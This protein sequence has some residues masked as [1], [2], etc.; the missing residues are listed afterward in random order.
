MIMKRIFILLALVISIA[1]CTSLPKKLNKAKHLIE[2]NGGF[3]LPNKDSLPGQCAVQ[4]PCVT[5][6]KQVTDSGWLVI[7]TDNQA[8]VDS[9]KK[10]I[11]SMKAVLANPPVVTDSASCLQAVQYYQRKVAQYAIDISQLTSQIK[12]SST[13]YRQRTEKFT[14][15]STA[16][17]AAKDEV[18]KALQKRNDELKASKDS[19][20]LLLQSEYEAKKLHEKDHHNI[21]KTF[22]WFIGAIWSAYWWLILLIGIA[23]GLYKFRKVL[24]ILK[25][26]PF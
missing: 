13:E 4:F 11:D 9:M 22:W 17:L 8:V 1:S 26:L 12:N 23:F 20:N 7:S 25:Y 16:K 15:E 10:V 6:E 21:S 14:V 19:T 18:I 3:V 2:D 5:T 24:P